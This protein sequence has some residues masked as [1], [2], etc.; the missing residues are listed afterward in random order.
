MIMDLVREASESRATALE[1]AIREFYECGVSLDRMEIRERPGVNE[2]VL[3][4][5]DVPRFTWRLVTNTGMDD[6]IIRSYD[7]TT[8]KV[9]KF[10]R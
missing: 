10:Q 7:P 1:A 8:P 6:D 4:V 2:S 9:D 3:Y 5:D